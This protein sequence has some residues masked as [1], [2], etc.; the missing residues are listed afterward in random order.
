MLE[1]LEASR[2]LE[3][4]S[5]GAFYARSPQLGA[6]LPFLFGGEDQLIL[7]SLLEKRPSRRFLVFRYFLTRLLEDLG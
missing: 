1:A 3:A 4:G 6:H 2:H 5:R 7:T